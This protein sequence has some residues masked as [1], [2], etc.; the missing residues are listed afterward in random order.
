MIIAINDLRKACYGGFNSADGIDLIIDK[1]E[2]IENSL[3]NLNNRVN[4]L[5]NDKFMMGGD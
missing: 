4:Q 1:L 2:E 5:E 3:N